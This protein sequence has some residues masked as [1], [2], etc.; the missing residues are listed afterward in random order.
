M[1]LFGQHKAHFSDIMVNMLDPKFIRE[2]PEL[3]KKA[4]SDKQLA[5]SVDVDK[6]LEVDAKYLGIL[7]KVE[8]KRN[9]KN[10]LS[11]DISKVKEKEVRDRLIGEASVIKEELA[12]LEEEMR[13]LKQELDGMMLW[14]P[15]IPAEDVPYGESEE[16]NK[17]IRQG[18]KQPKFS[19]EPKEHLE[20]GQNLGIIDVDRGVKIGGF[21]SYFLKNQGADL[22]KAILD[23]SLDVIR[24]KGFD[25]L[26][27]PWMV[28]P[29]YFQGTGYFPWGKDD[30]YFT[31]D[32]MALIGTAEVS[33]RV[34]LEFTNLLKS[35]K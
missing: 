16:D 15:N 23:Y 11:D 6:L 26:D 5:G 4:L 1:G 35:N 12:K 8:T 21:R 22:H 30:H 27:I 33:L 25:I 20:I 14:V 28:R 32:G 24:S 13:N 10:T 3:I 7:K 29:E 19:F 31:Q 18:G 17:V 9:L 2:N 34:Y